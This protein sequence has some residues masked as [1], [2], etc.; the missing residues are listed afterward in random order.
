MRWLIYGANGYTGTLCAERA[1]ELGLEPILAGRRAEVVQPIADRLGLTARAFA[2]DGPASVDRGLDGVQLVLH[3]AGPFS[4]TARP[5]IDG[6]L[7]ARAHY[8]D[9]TGEIAVYEENFGRSADFERAG[10][11]VMSGVGFDV[12][13]TD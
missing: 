7:R 10:I 11:V 5:M 4:A 12:V 8:L 6:C 1:R 2:L 13:P 9:I 3:C